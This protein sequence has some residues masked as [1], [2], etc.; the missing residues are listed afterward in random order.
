MRPPA[1]SPSADEHVIEMP[2][3]PRVP[4][5]AMSARHGSQDIPLL[6]IPVRRSLL[7]LPARAV[8]LAGHSGCCIAL[9]TCYGSVCMHCSAGIDQTY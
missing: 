7:W 3:V 6:D 5:A 9:S 8:E 1:A 4:K 2:D